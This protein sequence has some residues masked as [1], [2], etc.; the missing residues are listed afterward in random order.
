MIESK[1]LPR[2]MEFS[3]VPYSLRELKNDKI[4][5]EELCRKLKAEIN[6]FEQSIIGDRQT[7]KQHRRAII[8]ISNRAA[9]EADISISKA[10]AS[11]VF[12]I[13]NIIPAVRA[14]RTVFILIRNADRLRQS[15]IGLFKTTQEL[16]QADRTLKD[17]GD[18]VAR[19]VNQ[20]EMWNR[21]IN[22]KLRE[23][24]RLKQKLQ[25]LGCG[26]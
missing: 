20:I 3:S 1:K 8:Q 23:I 12:A 15:L 22:S 9:G 26:R 19:H 10:I 16:G 14:A 21:K 18:R 17:A 4:S 6:G 25:K 13:L 2:S 11:G 7:I 5:H 24:D